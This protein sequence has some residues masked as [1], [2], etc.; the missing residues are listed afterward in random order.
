MKNS[1]RLLA[2]NFFKIAPLNSIFYKNVDKIDMQVIITGPSYSWSKNRTTAYVS[3]N[4]KDK[5]VITL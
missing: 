4:L 5:G 2:V 3:D 1:F